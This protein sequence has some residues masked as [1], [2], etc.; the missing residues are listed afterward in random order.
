M[1]GLSGRSALITGGRRGI[2]RATALK[3][4]GLGVRVA[5]NDVT[6]QDE[7]DGVVGEI[8]NRGGE[9]MAI[10]SD[11][12]QE[13]PVKEMVRRVADQWGGIDILV[14]NHTIVRD[15]NVMRLTV[16]DWDTVME[17]NLRAYFLTTKYALR[18]MTARRWG[19][20]INLTSV[21]AI[22]GDPLRSNYCASKGGVISFT[23]SVSREV[24][25]YNITVNA[26]APG[27]IETKMAQ[28]SIAEV[29]KKL[30]LGRLALGHFGKPEDIAGA[31]AFLAGD[32]AA[33]ITG[34]VIQVDG[35]YL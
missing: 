5:V 18:S 21:A 10:L 4:A 22:V 15:G 32:D 34:Q 26:V 27:L 2:G 19:R 7:L 8:Q 12:A 1:A 3:L 24:G 14:N 35:G 20:V 23:K 25:R 29:E 31:I 9:A 16:E 33:Y 28:L 11:A 30:V 17:V 13:A 6:G